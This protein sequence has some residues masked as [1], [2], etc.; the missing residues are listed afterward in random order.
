LKRCSHCHKQKE[1]SEFYKEKGKKFGVR[2]ICKK[3]DYI[4]RKKWDQD[5]PERARERARRYA[6]RTNYAKQK[7]WEK[8]HPQKSAE[9]HRR[10]YYNHRE[11]RLLW[12]KEYYNLNREKLNKYNKDR[13]NFKKL[14]A[15]VM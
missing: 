9:I 7:K 14:F 8:T 15:G 12:Y 3:C 11:E 2:H 5:N 13:C 10:Y 6:K 1:L 4:K